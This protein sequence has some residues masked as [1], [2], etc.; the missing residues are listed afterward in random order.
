MKQLDR[1]LAALEAHTAGADVFGIWYQ[2]ESWNSEHN[3]GLVRVCGTDERLTE[4]AF[5]E[6]YP[7]GTLVRVIYTDDWKAGSMP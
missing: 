6:R 7:N 4:E 3:D 2:P 1:C 5:A